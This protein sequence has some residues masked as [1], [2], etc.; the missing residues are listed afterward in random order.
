MLIDP[1]TH[2]WP[3]CRKEGIPEF[4]ARNNIPSQAQ[5][6]MWQRGQRDGNYRKNIAGQLQTLI[7]CGHDKTCPSSSQTKFEERQA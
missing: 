7:H 6:P 3:K 5:V 2:N 4:S 1:E